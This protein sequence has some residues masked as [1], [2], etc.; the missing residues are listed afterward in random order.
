MTG[1]DLDQLVQAD[2]EAAV[3]RLHY[4]TGASAIELLPI[5]LAVI[6]KAMNMHLGPGITLGA[7]GCAV[8]HVNATG[9]RKMN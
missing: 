9:G 7:L 4:Q 2:L 8:D 3:S 5:A 1:N 6:V